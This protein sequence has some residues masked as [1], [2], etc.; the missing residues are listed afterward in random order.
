MDIRFDFDIIGVP[1]KDTADKISRTL[2]KALLENFNTG[3]SLEWEDTSAEWS[4][5]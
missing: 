2:E 5:D 4:M 3:I 1:D